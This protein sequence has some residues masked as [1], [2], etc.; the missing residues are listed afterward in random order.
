MSPYRLA[1]EAVALT[2]EPW[3]LGRLS[4]PTSAGAPARAALARRNTPRSGTHRAG[5]GPGE[6]RA[7]R[8][9]ARRALRRPRPPGPRPSARPDRAGLA[10]CLARP[11]EC[12]ANHGSPR[13]PLPR[14]PEIRACSG[15]S[16]PCGRAGRSRLLR[17]HH[18]GED[19]EIALRVAEA[20]LPRAIE[21]RVWLLDD[22]PRLMRPRIER[23]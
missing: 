1:V 23:I 8:R 18:P 9:S 21:C 12:A 10:R 17:A 2:L 13:R 16:F 14:F 19:E 6:R 20:K 22:G 3:R 11:Q 15:V 5:S 4:M 7:A